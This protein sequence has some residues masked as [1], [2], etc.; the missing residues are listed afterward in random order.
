MTLFVWPSQSLVNRVLPKNKVY[1]NAT[2]SARL[3][4]AFVADLHQI[5]WRA[6]L[7]P[8]TV[9][10]AATRDVP[11]I[12]V[13]E[14]ALKGPE[15]NADIARTIDGSIPFP[16]VFELTF[17]RKIRILAAWKRPT[18]ADPTKWVLGDYLETPWQAADAP[19][20]ALPV[21]L[22]M[23]GLY[24][25]IL[26]ALSPQPTRL[27][28]TL[29]EHMERLGHIRALEAESEKLERK[30]A[31]ERQFNRKVEINRQIR[32]V[33]NEIAGLSDDTSPEKIDE[34]AE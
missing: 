29:A 10:L 7:A 12:Q 18:A 26:R 11:E 13:F 22:D 6:K 17:E 5:I 33:R 20:E 3:R 24:E 31:Q 2:I 15:F 25:Q 23:G 19:R 27:E 1:A 21:A 16:I 14:L 32:A 9:R 30:L 28:E 34:S 4:Q 8:E